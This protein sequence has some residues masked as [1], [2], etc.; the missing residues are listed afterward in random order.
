LHTKAG[1]QWYVGRHYK[2]FGMN[3]GCGIDHKSYAMAYAYDFPK[4]VISCGVVLNN[5]KLPIVE[6][7]EL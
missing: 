1:I 7:M 3:V 2:I 4:P 6:P 5:G